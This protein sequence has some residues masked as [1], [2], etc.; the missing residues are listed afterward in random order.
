MDILILV[1]V[2]YHAIRGLF[3]GMIRMLC[4][5]LAIGAALWAAIQGA[6][7]ANAI[8]SHWVSLPYQMGIWGSGL[9]IAGIVFVIV[10]SIGKFLDTLTSTIGLG[11]FNRFAGCIFGCI[12]GF[13]LIVPLAMILNIAA[14]KLVKDS[15]ILSHYAPILTHFKAF[16]LPQ[17]GLPGSD[18]LGETLLQSQLPNT[19]AL[20]AKLLEAQIPT[21][22]TQTQ[23][24]R[25]DEI[26]HAVRQLH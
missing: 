24:I 4:D 14:P 19:D 22:N 5:I 16:S 20:A 6:A 25:Q 11:I 12:K 17:L 2:A 10:S 8:L 21:L 13:G 9:V 3:R 7:P 26:E 18:G 23:K 15:V 1:W